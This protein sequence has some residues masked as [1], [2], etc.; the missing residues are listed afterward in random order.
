M[1][2]LSQMPKMCLKKKWKDLGYCKHK[3]YNEQG[4]K[5]IVSISTF[6]IG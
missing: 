1:R 3:Q 2:Y 5:E 6:R 4:K